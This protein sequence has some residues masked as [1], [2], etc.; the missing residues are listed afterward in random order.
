MGK[1]MFEYT[2]NIISKVIFSE[3]VSKKE[4]N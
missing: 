3:E 2:K 4:Q 1:A